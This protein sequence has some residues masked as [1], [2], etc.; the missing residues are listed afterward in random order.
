MATEGEQQ[1][2]ASG[3]R[4]FGQEELAQIVVKWESGEYTLADLA[5]EFNRPPSSLSR[6]LKQLGKEK[7]SNAL[8]LV[9]EVRSE[10]DLATQTRKQQMIE[11]KRN[12]ED[13]HHKIVEYVMY[14]MTNAAKALPVMQAA[15]DAKEKP[16]GRRPTMAS[17]KGEMDTYKKM[18]EI[19]ALGLEQRLNTL[20]APIE[21]LVDEESL[22]TVSIRVMSP[23]EEDEIQI[24]KSLEGSHDPPEHLK[25][26]AK[27]LGL[28]RENVSESVS[29]D[30]SDAL[31]INTPSKLVIT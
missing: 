23:E 6:K 11:K 10:V 2:E 7:G 22:T 27:E 29:E 30:P 28:T 25:E 20:G 19:S 12:V 21:S 16:E 13:Q 26:K 5:E 24:R 1:E 3:N 8:A 14:M 9:E 17:L 15:W 4:P 18:L 31:K